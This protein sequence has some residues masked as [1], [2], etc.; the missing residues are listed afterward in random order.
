MSRYFSIRGARRGALIAFV[1][2]GI[3]IAW[4]VGYSQGMDVHSPQM[5]LISI[6]Q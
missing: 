1:T 5:S 6:S 4:A 2:A 3:W